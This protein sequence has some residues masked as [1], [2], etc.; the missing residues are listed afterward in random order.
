MKKEQQTRRAFIFSSGVALIG[1]SLTT[2]AFGQKA[3]ETFL[4]PDGED[5]NAV[6]AKL[7]INDFLP[8][9]GET[10]EVYSTEGKRLRLQ[11]IA[12]DNECETTEWCK[13]AAGDSFSLLFEAPRKSFYK[14]DVYSFDH[15]AMGKFQLLLVPVGLTGRRFEAVINRKQEEAIPAT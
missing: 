2:S 8:H 11:L 4:L 14:Q 5:P 13:A 3:V 12:A 7:G 15:F 10:F 6:L 9:V 1:A